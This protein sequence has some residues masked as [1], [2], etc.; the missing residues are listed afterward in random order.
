M[1]RD[2]PNYKEKPHQPSN[3]RNWYKAYKKILKESEKEIVKDAE[4]LKATL[5]GI[6]SE[7]AKHKLKRV[8]LDFVKLPDGVGRDAP[9]I[10]LPNKIRFT[11]RGAQHGYAPSQR[12][13]KI[14][15]GELDPN[16][17]RRTSEPRSK[18]SKLD[19]L[20]KEAKGM[21]HFQQPKRPTGI[22]TGREMALKPRPTATTISKAPRALVEEHRAA[23]SPKPIDPKTLI[24][25]VI[26]PR[27][28][29]IEHTAEE[30]PRGPTTEEREKRLKAFTSPSSMVKAEP[31][32]KSPRSRTTAP[33]ASSTTP[34]PTK[35]NP[36]LSI[37][38]SSSSR[39]LPQITS[40]LSPSSKAIMRESLAAEEQTPRAKSSSPSNGGL[41][42][43]KMVKKR[44]PVDIFMRPNK[45]LRRS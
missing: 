22:I 38:K 13:I 39:V 24:T 45:K 44:V 42:P 25:P 33:A 30:R 41:A 14:N 19:Q 35:N 12:E 34:S 28:R 17:A 16:A 3:P 40:S 36:Q 2:V 18:L 7:K 9:I 20:R 6:N 43:P 4:L 21:G 1:E 31:D 15:R 26:A 5:D 10:H 27:K 8:D 23:S 11:D 29:K 37:E 32:I